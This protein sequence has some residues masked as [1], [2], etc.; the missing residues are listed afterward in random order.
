[1]LQFEM[2]LKMEIAM[3]HL[4]WTKT[5]THCNH[6]II[7]YYRTKEKMKKK[8]IQSNEWKENPKKIFKWIYTKIKLMHKINVENRNDFD[9]NQLAVGTWWCR[10]TVSH[11]DTLHY[12]MNAIERQTRAERATFIIHSLKNYVKCVWPWLSVIF[13]LL[14][15]TII[16]L[17]NYM[18]E[19]EMNKTAFIFC[20]NHTY[21]NIELTNRQCIL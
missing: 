4:H 21:C 12:G 10:H 5:F 11:K 7:A 19:N 18:N 15:L 17:K 16:C 13:S 1:M 6:S 9:P 20:I 3:I 2:Q 8:R 14:T